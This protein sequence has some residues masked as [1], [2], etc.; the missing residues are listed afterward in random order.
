MAFETRTRTDMEPIE[1]FVVIGYEGDG[2][3]VFGSFV[4][5]VHLTEEGAKKRSND[6]NGCPTEVKPYT[7]QP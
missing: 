2:V 1:G 7:I 5:G 6:Y 3:D 4:L